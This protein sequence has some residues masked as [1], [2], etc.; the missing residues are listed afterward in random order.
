MGAE[1]MTWPAV[2]MLGIWHGLNPGMGWLFAV[3]LGMQDRSRA[4]VWRALGPLA[5]GHGIAIAATVLLAAVAGLALPDWVLRWSIALTLVTFGVF[6]LVSGRHPVYGGMRVNGRELTTWSA[7]MATAHGAGLMVVPFV[8][9]PLHQ[10]TVPLGHAAH[11][12]AIPASAGLESAVTATLVHSAG[13]LAITAVIAVV[14][15]ERLGVAILRRVWV[16]LDL[17]WAIALVLTGVLTVAA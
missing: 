6:K 8:L 2:L 9:P 7:L 3:S 11:M 1:S 5:A 16:N 10:P 4:A 14:V 17:V 15:Y 12:G 13:Y